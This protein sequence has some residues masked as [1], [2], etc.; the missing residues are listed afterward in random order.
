[1]QRKPTPQSRG[2]NAKER[3]F[4]GIVKEMDCIAC[5]KP[6]P[7]IVDHI[8]GS[9]KKL[10]NG[11]ERVMVGHWAVIPLC[12]ICDAVKT[13]GSRKAFEKAFG[14]QEELWLRMLRENDLQNAVPHNVKSAIV[15]ECLPW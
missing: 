1:M 3:W 13:Q 8:Y 12:Y 7:S 2:P 11:P 6:G 10:Y 4:H 9:S 15:G 5:G 14:Q